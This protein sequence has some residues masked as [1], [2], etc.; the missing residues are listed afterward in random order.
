MLVLTTGAM[1]GLVWTGLMCQQSTKLSSATSRRK[2][3]MPTLTSGYIVMSHQVDTSAQV[4]TDIQNVYSRCQNKID[5]R[6]RICGRN[7]QN[8]GFDV[9]I[10]L[11]KNGPGHKVVSTF[12]TLPREYRCNVECDLRTLVP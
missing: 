8:M 1:S 3:L 9:I 6:G 11:G 10:F 5:T 12:A 2:Y 4:F 7:Y